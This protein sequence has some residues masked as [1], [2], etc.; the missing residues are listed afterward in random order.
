MTDEPTAPLPAYRGSE[1]IV[2]KGLEDVETVTNALAVYIEDMAEKHGN[3]EPKY[4]AGPWIDSM[5]D[6][7]TH[8]DAVEASDGSMIALFGPDRSAWPNRVL[9]CKNEQ[10]LARQH[11][12]DVMDAVRGTAKYAIELR[13]RIVKEWGYDPT[14]ES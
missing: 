12:V 3:V 11:I 9:L 4:L 6:Q 8:E 5:D 14:Y 1:Q 13:Q 10:C 7:C 2:L